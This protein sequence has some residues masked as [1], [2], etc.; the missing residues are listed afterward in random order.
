VIIEGYLRKVNAVALPVSW[1][2]ELD[3]SWKEAILN[4]INLKM[5]QE[6]FLDKEIVISIEEVTDETAYLSSTEANR[7]YSFPQPT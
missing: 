7:Y 6:T 4:N 2:L 3:F 5:I 1:D